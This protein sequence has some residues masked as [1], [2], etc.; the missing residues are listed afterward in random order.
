MSVKR[1]NKSTVR[2]QQSSKVRLFVK[3]D[4]FQLI[5]DLPQ[6][7]AVPVGIKGQKEDAVEKAAI[8]LATVKADATSGNIR[9]CYNSYYLDRD[10]Y[11]AL[12]S[13]WEWSEMDLLDAVS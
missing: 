7:I 4:A 11:L 3:Q 9:G 10:A 1:N 13:D 12:R 6:I 5:E 8:A 2:T